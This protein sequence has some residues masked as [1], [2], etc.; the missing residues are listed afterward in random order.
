MVITTP[1]ALTASVVRILGVRWRGRCLLQPKLERQPGCSC[2]RVGTRRTS[3]PPP[4]SVLD[5]P[6][7]DLAQGGEPV[8]QLGG[9]FGWGRVSWRRWPAGAPPL[10]VG[11]A[12][13]ENCAAG[14]HPDDADE[15]S[16]CSL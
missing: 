10:R 11:A 15:E 5:L 12:Q 6:A 16:P 2:Q 13:G 4:D 9:G 8:Q 7:A 3:I 14:E 1:E